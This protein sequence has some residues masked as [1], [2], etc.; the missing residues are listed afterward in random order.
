MTSTELNEKKKFTPI[1]KSFRVLVINN[2]QFF[3]SS[4]FPSTH[5]VLYFIE[6]KNSS[7]T[8]GFLHFLIKIS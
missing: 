5:E 1:L 8:H 6:K 7:M 2:T 3:I 4:F